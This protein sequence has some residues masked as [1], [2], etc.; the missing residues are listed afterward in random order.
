MK[1]DGNN[2][3]DHS[4]NK[5]KRVG[6]KDIM[7]LGVWNVRGLRNKE[8]ELENEL[9]SKRINIAVI[10]ET[11][12]KCKGT[13][14]LDNYVMIYNG[15]PQNERA[16][17]GVAILI[18]KKWKNKLHSYTFINDRILMTRFNIERGHLTI[19]GVYAPEEGKKED[20]EEFY[21]NLQK[22]LHK[23]NKK[24][25]LIIAGDLNA[26]VGNI[27]IPNVI[28]KFG[29]ETINKNGEELKEFVTY[30]DLK[31]TNTF[32]RKKDIH[33]Y[34]W[35]ARG[36]RSIIDYVIANRKIA[37]QI[38][39]TTVYR[40]NDVNSD[41]FLVMSKIQI[42]A[43]WKR[44]KIKN[45][46][47][48]ETQMYKIYLLN[49]ES[50]RNLYQTRINSIT[51]NTPIDLDINKEWNNIQGIIK[52]AANEA[53]GSK[54]KNRRRKGLRIWTPEIAA[55][56]EEK[57]EAYKKMLQLNTEETKEIYKQK[58]NY[59][60]ILVT[61]AHQESWDRFVSNIEN[62]I[63]GR[64][65]IAYKIMRHLNTEEKDNAELNIIKEKGWLEHYRKLWY[66]PE[67]E[68]E[69]STSYEVYNIDPLTMDEFEEALQK[70]KNRKAPGL[71]GINLELIKYSGTTLKQ[72]LLHLL[73]LCWKNCK[74][75]DEWTKA[76]V[77]SLF[78]KGNRSSPEN[79]RGITLLNVAYKIYTKIINKRFTTISDKILLE[80]QNGFRHGRSC[81]DDIFTINMVI[82][83]RREHNLET[84][85]GFID[86]EKAFDTL[87]RKT[88]WKIMER[89]GIPLH[90]I[91]VIKSIYA[92]TMNR[93]SIKGKLS[94]EF[95]I[96]KGVRQGCSLSPSLFNI[97]IDDILREWKKCT[98]DGISLNRQNILNTLLFADDQIIIQDSEDNLQK[99]I[100]KLNTICGEYHLKISIQKTKVMAFRGKH[101]VRSKIIINNT[102]IE[103]V[104]HFKYLGC[105]ITY[106]YD[107][108]V[109]IKTQ[110]FQA[111]CGTIAKNL[112]KK[113][114]KETQ[115]KFYKT[116]A[117]P[118]LL[119][120]CEAWTLKKNDINRIQSAEMKFLRGVKG[121][122][123][124][125]R[126]RND[127][128]RNELNLLPIIDKIK[129][130]RIRWSNHLRRMDKERIPKQ[131]LDYK[132]QGRRD[133]GRPRTRWK[134][135]DGTG[136]S[137]TP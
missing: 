15:K 86:Y 71:D 121:C 38:I 108:D 34:T 7:N 109:N 135:E 134:V 74:I 33:K 25:Y 127:D 65:E 80:E 49:Q 131:V 63:H 116:M 91:Q 94:E 4:K 92:K 84:H 73:N 32:F 120:G 2:G 55:A 89:R 88:L 82:Q 19:I 66:D 12:L 130:Y 68:E 39:D 53:L 13:K 48:T 124:L 107:K 18:D 115:I 61:K 51:A 98:N 27:N 54:T 1:P 105:D 28:G 103:Q 44:N 79:Y 75:P 118:T 3:D 119:Y 123:R 46:P 36:S 21:E 42:M 104:S 70:S 100:H 26:R 57:K 31:I 83:K 126:Y 56:I 41:H 99:A 117:I 59:S 14:D 122:T 9:M 30:N 129:E 67:I 23:W 102:V 110:R 106:D 17:S 16:S 72:R 29:E 37:S 22:Q 64:Q 136:D 96:N 43:R 111:I 133:I 45:V 35:S 113:T 20:T 60:K 8:K 50:I 125:D 10:S 101:P 58:R 78:K 137:P 93:I 81:M 47:P 52:I 11:K 62:D 95:M 87:H 40:G 85:I 97:Y 114:R 112:K 90:L 69:D 76:K 77:I 132:P 24:D 5:G 128:I 6:I